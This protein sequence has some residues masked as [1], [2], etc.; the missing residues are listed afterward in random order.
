MVCDTAFLLFKKMVIIKNTS[1]FN[2]PKAVVS[3]RNSHLVKPIDT[4]VHNF[5]E[6]LELAEKLAKNGGGTG[7]TNFRTGILVSFD[8]KYPQ[9]FA[10]QIQR[11]HFL[12]IVSSTSTMHSILKMD[13]DE[14]CNKYVK[15]EVKDML[16]KL[17]SEYNSEKGSWD[18]EKRYE[19]Y[20]EIISNCPMGLE[21]W[22][23]CTT[24]YEQLATIY[25]QRKNHKL[26]E[27][28]G[29]F[30]NWIKSLPYSRLITC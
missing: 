16:N 13:M 8:L 26:K 27:D 24:N 2:M 23:H 11:Y 18:S 22:C 9:Y 29:E 1:V 19:K 4:T 7:H 5:E 17:I 21:L 30:C 12:Q 15:K 10:R 6:S 3:V 14:C 28:W 20:M 25:K